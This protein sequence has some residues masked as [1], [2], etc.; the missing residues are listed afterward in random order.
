MDTN[1]SQEVLSIIRYVECVLL[2][3]SLKVIVGTDKIMTPRA[4]HAVE[5]SYDV[6]VPHFLDL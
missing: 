3:L 1:L 6:I 4:G 5:L 2:K